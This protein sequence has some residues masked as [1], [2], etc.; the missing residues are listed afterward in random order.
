MAHCWFLSSQNE[1]YVRQIVPNQFSIRQFGLNIFFPEILIFLGFSKIQIFKILLQCLTFDIII[2]LKN[3]P[4]LAAQPGIAQV[5]SNNS[6]FSC[7]VQCCANL[8]YRNVISLWLKV[9]T[10]MNRFLIWEL[11][12]SLTDLTPGETQSIS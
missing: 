6:P 11:G 10:C 8:G 2:L 3:L 7:S 1:Y 4:I 12:R 9:L 5:I